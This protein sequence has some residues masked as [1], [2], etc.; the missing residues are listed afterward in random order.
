[1]VEILDQLSPETAP[2]KYYVGFRYA[3]PLTEDAIDQMVRWVWIYKSFLHISHFNNTYLLSS[4]SPYLYSFLFFLNLFPCLSL[5][6]PLL[7]LP[8]YLPSDGVERAVAFSQY[9]Q[10]S[11]STSG[12][13]FN[14]I[15]RHLSKI[16]G[17]S[18]P[19]QWSVIDRWPVHSGLVKVP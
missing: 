16:G 6:P 7:H 5:S 15:Y 13:S 11:C 8:T 9:Q 2:H 1:M 14:Q 18:G 12:S 3:N 19:M 17:L 10:Y 4:F